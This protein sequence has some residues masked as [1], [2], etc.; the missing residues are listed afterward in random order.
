[1]NSQQLNETLTLFSLLILIDGKIF[2]EE[3]EVMV[4][5]LAQI[6]NSTST[7]ILFT[8]AMAKDWF[9]NNVKSLR[10]ILESDDHENLMK[11]AVFKLAKYEDDLRLK[12]YDAMI[13]IAHADGECHPTE[14][15]MVEHAS[16]SWGIEHLNRRRQS[17]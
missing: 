10:M 12:I 2:P 9:K 14:I 15:K 7:D 3:L 5:Q 13:R 11:T 8:P 6:Q 1:M 4:N 16:T 17:G